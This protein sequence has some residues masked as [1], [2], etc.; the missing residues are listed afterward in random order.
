MTLT[1]KPAAALE[2]DIDRA[3]GLFATDMI[4][5][6]RLVRAVIDADAGRWRAHLVLGFFQS[7]RQRHDLA[8]AS[9]EK[10]VALNPDHADCHFNIGY[11]ARQLGDIDRA[12]RAYG[13]A[14]RLAPGGHPVARVLRACCRHQAGDPA[15]AADL[16]TS[17]LAD[18]PGLDIG[19]YARA[20]ARHDAGA[21]DAAR[22]ALA[23]L[24]AGVPD[25]DRRA[26]ELVSFHARYDFPGWRP[27]DDK[28][29]LGALA[30]AYL[31]AGGRPAFPY[32]PEVFVLPEGRAEWQAAHDARPG[33]WI[34]KGAG[35]SGGQA[36]HVVAVPGPVPE[37]DAWIAQRYV[38]DPLLID[39]RKFN[40]RLYLLVD[41]VKPLRA[42][43][44]SGGVATLA[45]EPYRTDPAGLGRRAA[46]VINPLALD[47]HLDMKV[48]SSLDADG[49]G[50]VWS[51][52][53]LF[54][55]LAGRG[56]DTE[57]AWR[58]LVGLGAGLVRLAAFA[59]I[60]EEQTAGGLEQAYPPKLLGMDV[61]LDAA[62]QPHL[63]EVERFPG[64]SAP[65]HDAVSNAVKTRL[66]GAVARLVLTPDAEAPATA[67]SPPGRT[68][69]GV[70]GTGFFELPLAET[71]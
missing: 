63:L 65:A 16:L 19:D 53:A 20:R 32:Y 7:R 56:V 14:A 42:R 9:L 21:P 41:R 62:L 50:N 54:E 26:T 57:L 18:H 29:A 30:A 34:L 6:E 3:L 28:A 59:G 2:A 24:A 71:A 15:G 38:A 10:A 17:L 37:H 66:R 12:E 52:A 27:L 40:M 49:T 45:P 5:A 31:R 61:M 8:L 46:H 60:V 25:D 68:A 51:L 67:P 33:P 55:T 70:L 36:A 11:L 1:A 47:G 23:A 64:L 48:A 58:R 44:W 13:Q 35:L 39:A 22:R 4:A 43:M 69:S